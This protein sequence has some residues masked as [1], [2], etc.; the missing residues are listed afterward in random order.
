MTEEE[1]AALYRAQDAA[2]R[3][4]RRDQYV[5]L[6]GNRSARVALDLAWQPPLLA[7]LEA[8]AHGDDSEFLEE[9]YVEVPPQDI[10][11]SEI[12]DSLLI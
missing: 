9:L 12:P 7:S 3:Q 5:A 6:A 10:Y 11:V 1:R 8:Q 2:R 4:A